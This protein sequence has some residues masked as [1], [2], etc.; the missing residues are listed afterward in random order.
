MDYQPRFFIFIFFNDRPIKTTI[1]IWIQI[2]SP[3]TIGEKGKTLGQKKKGIKW[4]GILKTL[5]NTLKTWIT[6]SHGGTS[7][8]TYGNKLLTHWE[9]TNKKLHPPT[10]T[11]KKEKKMNLLTCV[12]Y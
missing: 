10:H 11:P 5:W 8:Q 4:G 12:C 7:M 1:F 9:H 3:F 2:A 6:T